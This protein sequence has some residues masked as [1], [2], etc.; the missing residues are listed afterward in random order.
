MQDAPFAQ[1]LRE[2]YDTQVVPGSFFEAPGAVR[3][4]FGVEPA[5]LEQGLANL[6]AALDDLA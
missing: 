1:H 6:S 5:I 3:L 2:R 4:S